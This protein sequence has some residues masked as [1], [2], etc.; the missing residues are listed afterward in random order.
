MGVPYSVGCTDCDALT[1]DGIQIR[2]HRY[3]CTVN[4]FGKGREFE[5]RMADS[6]ITRSSLARMAGNIAAGYVTGTLI[7]GS[8]EEVAAECIELAK[9]IARQLSTDD[10]N[11]V[12]GPEW[13]DRALRAESTVA[14]LAKMMGW[15]N[16]PPQRTLEMNLSALKSSVTELRRISG[17][18]GN[19]SAFDGFN[20][21][22][23]KVR[24]LLEV[25][26]TNDPR[27]EAM[28]TIADAKREQ[29][30]EDAAIVRRWL[31]HWPNR[32]GVDDLALSPNAE[33]LAQAIMSGGTEDPAKQWA[34]LVCSEQAARSNDPEIFKGPIRHREDETCPNGGTNPFRPKAE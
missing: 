1:V 15:E 12:A 13:K 28:K 22:L 20:T 24:A 26:K 11:Y 32:R 19:A 2:P 30:I 33:E 18:L 27:G 16:V 21:T 7:K 3:G 5:K 10:E 4:A 17:L 23:D 14:S 25:S 9:A 34:C 29:K 8:R 6:V 31:C